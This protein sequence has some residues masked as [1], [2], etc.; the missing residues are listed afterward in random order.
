MRNQFL[1]SASTA[2]VSDCD[3]TGTSA[4]R[5]SVL[6]SWCWYAGAQDCL[7]AGRWPGPCQTHVGTGDTADTEYHGKLCPWLKVACKL[8]P[9]LE[10]GKVACKLCPWLEV[11]KVACKLCLWLEVGKVA[12]KLCLWLEVG[13]VA[14]KLCPW[15]EACKLC[16]C[17]TSYFYV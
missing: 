3:R 7:R 10:V 9:W 1:T 15:L 6:C 16:R 4:L 13:K 14:C 12:C 8:C 2:A 5:L 17:S 11:G